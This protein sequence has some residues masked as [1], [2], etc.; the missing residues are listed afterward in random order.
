M[1]K[2][3]ISQE[4]LSQALNLVSKAVSNR[5]LNLVLAHIRLQAK[6]KSLTLTGSD[7]DF[8][9]EH[10]IEVNCDREGALLVPARLFVDLLSRM[11]KKDVILERQDGVLKITSGFSVYE[12]NILADENF[13]SL[14]LFE[15]GRLAQIA[16]AQLKAALG[17][18][19]FSAS[20]DIGGTTSH[21]THGVLLNFHEDSLDIV[22]TDGHR[23]AFEKMDNPSPDVKD[24]SLLVPTNIM[25]E[26]RRAIGSEDDKMVE[27]YYLSNQ[28]F[29]RFDNTTFG[30]SLFDI[31][32][33]DYN[34]VL[35]KDAKSIAN[36]NRVALREALQRVLTVFK[37]KE[38]NPVVRLETSGD[39]V[40]ISS[41]SQDVGKGVEELPFTKGA[42][43]ADM[44][45]ALNPGY[46][47][48]MLAV[49]DSETVDLHWT[50]EVNPLKLEVP[51]K[52]G[53][54]Y[55]VMPIRMD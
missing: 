31:R 8:T 6:K 22:A 17:R 51:E 50:S 18:T 11:P 44:R 37:V 15:E 39:S 21:Y 52:P 45:I 54:V 7:G 20:R 36:V 28:V 53:F 16:S 35:P 23:L 3:T 13:P 5:T 48:D 1:M 42:P 27:I 38:Q 26:L 24:R 49:L 29:F 25:E 46:V 10:T 9:I 33:P 34:K 14:P 12:I 4:R 19:T 47:V 32:Y 55:I 43:F 30:G 2:L 40:I 41:E